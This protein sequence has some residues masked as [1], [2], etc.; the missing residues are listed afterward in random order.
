MR[1]KSVVQSHAEP[2]FWIDGLACLDVLFCVNLSYS[3]RERIYINTHPNVAPTR[4][5]GGTGAVTVAVAGDRVIRPAPRLLF[6]DSPKP[7]VSIARLSAI[8]PAG[9]WVNCGTTLRL[10][11]FT[12]AKQGNSGKKSR[13]CQHDGVLAA[14]LL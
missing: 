13:F 5:A 7:Q 1:R 14:V 6:N 4:T 11:C 10:I 9:V 8:R 3:D 2:G 12:E